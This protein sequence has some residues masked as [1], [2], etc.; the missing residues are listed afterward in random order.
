MATEKSA[1]VVGTGMIG[2]LVVQALRVAGF[3]KVIAVDVDP[4]KL[5]LASELGASHAVNAEQERIQ[6]VMK[7]DP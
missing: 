6:E 4:F 7:F 2:L 3:E 1:V 5:K